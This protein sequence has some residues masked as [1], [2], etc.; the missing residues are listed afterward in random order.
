MDV[1]TVG[2]FV[3]QGTRKCIIFQRADDPE[4]VGPDYIIGIVDIDDMQGEMLV[5][6][7]LY[8]QED[9]ESVMNI[10]INERKGSR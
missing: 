3:I 1:E 2:G 9:F 5:V 8:T 10:L 7:E 4:A 6:G